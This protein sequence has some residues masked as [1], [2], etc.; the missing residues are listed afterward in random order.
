MYRASAN[1]TAVIMTARCNRLAVPRLLIKMH[2]QSRV[3]NKSQR[4]WHFFCCLILQNGG[5]HDS[6]TSLINREETSESHRHRMEP[7]SH[8]SNPSDKLWWLFSLLKLTGIGIPAC[9]LSNKCKK[10]KKKTLLI[11]PPAE[12]YLKEEL[13]MVFFL[14]G[15]HRRWGE[16]IVT[17]TTHG[18]EEASAE[19][20]A[21]WLRW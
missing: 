10:K 2:G 20:K 6:A 7:S 15:F 4:R 19:I 11:F 17:G 16:G 5:N 1:G 8:D 18:S 9:V 21:A 12:S 3:W 13:M 14:G